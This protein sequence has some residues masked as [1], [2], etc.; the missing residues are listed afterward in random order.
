MDVPGTDSSRPRVSVVMPTYNA[1]GYIAAA[2]RSALDPS[3][4]EVE[5]L[6]VDDGST[7]GS[8]A[9]VHAIDDSRIS[10]IQIPAS[11]GPARPRNIGIA[12]ARA[13]YVSLLD[14]DDLLKPGKLAASVAILDRCPSAGFAFGDYERMDVDANVFE[15]SVAHRHPVLRGLKSE[16]AGAD[17]RLIPQAAL[18]RGLLYE[19]FIGTSGVVLR[20]NLAMTLGG[21]DETISNSDDR[22]LWFRLAHSGD[23]VY[24]TSLGY[25]YRVHSASISHRSPIRN[26]ICRIAVLRRERARWRDRAARRQLD[27]L[28]A[29]EYAVIAQQQRLQR[30]RWAAMRSYLRAYTIA[31]R[32]T[33]L[34]GLIV[35]PIFDPEDEG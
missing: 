27:L 1:E 23:A 22:D 9:E 2:V 14:A 13:P 29:N 3:L 6:V 16:A 19:N 25:S 11:G 24:S 17:W 8:V 5:V 18:A 20:R 10:V 31:P 26:A 12:R 35:A 30:E 33:F 32:S 4:P 34:F 7:D 15:T 28:I 21:F